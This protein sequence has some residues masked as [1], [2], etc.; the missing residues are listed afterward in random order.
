MAFEVK[1]RSRPPPRHRISQHPIGQAARNIA[2]GDAGARE[3]ASVMVVALACSVSGLLMGLCLAAAH[4]PALAF[5][6]GAALAGSGA[7]LAR[8]L[9]QDLPQDGSE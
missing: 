2:A 7:W 3:R 6:L 4:W 5:V 8:G 1:G 9:V